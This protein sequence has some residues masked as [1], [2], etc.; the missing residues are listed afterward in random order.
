MK[1]KF[2]VKSLS[3]SGFRG[4]IAFA[5]FLSLSSI[6]ASY[7]A[8]A[9]TLEEQ[10]ARLTT[11]ATLL[12]LDRRILEAQKAI[13][14]TQQAIEA[15]AF[16]EI[17][18]TGAPTGAISA[19]GVDFES[20]VLAYRA[21]ETVASDIREELVRLLGS[22][23]ALVMFEPSQISSLLSDKLAYDAFINRVQSITEE[24]KSLNITRGESPLTTSVSFLFD[25]LPI[26][27]TDSS[28]S[29]A[30]VPKA[31]ARAFTARLVSDFREAGQSQVSVYYPAEYPLVS[32]DG[33]QN[34]ID[35]VTVLRSLQQEA[36]DEIEELESQQNPSLTQTRITALQAAS[37]SVEDLVSSLSTGNLFETIAKAE[38]LEEIKKDKAV[39][40]MSVEVLVGGTNRTSRGFFSSSLRHSGGSIVDYIVYDSELASI[41]FSNSRDAYTGFTT[42]STD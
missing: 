38:T 36:L 5:A 42:V 10:Q 18:T 40:Y 28:F 2:Q 22:D 26:F 25:L 35:E 12:E 15:S 27:R 29:G 31:T 7:T 16:P 13:Q 39:Y 11:E 33:T 30:A 32:V 41:R 37:K 14:E 20:T 23:F 1:Q 3:R 19:T 24:Y 6:G 34:I 17:N 4:L 9:E 21:L 8:K